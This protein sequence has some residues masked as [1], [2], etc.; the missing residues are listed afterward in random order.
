MTTKQWTALGTVGTFIAIFVTI[1]IFNFSNTSSTPLQ[2]NE[3]NVAIGNTA[4]VSQTINKLD[5]PPPTID[6]TPLTTNDTDL[7]SEISNY[8]SEYTLEVRTKSPIVD[9]PI[10]VKMPASIVYEIGI[11][12]DVYDSGERWSPGEAHVESGY[13]YFN[14]KNAGGPYILQFEHNEPE[15]MSSKDITVLMK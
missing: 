8:H 4:L 14:I 2:V 12:K 10:K 5:V 6:L 11:Y 1:V 15:H 3:S 7:A 9:L 13:A